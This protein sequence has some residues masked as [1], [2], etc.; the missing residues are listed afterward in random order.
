MPKSGRKKTVTPAKPNLLH[1]PGFRNKT[2]K[3]PYECCCYFCARQYPSNTATLQVP[4]QD[5]PSFAVCWPLVR[6]SLPSAVSIRGSLQCK[7]LDGMSFR[8]MRF[9]SGDIYSN[10]PVDRLRVVMAWRLSV[11][12]SALVK[13]MYTSHPLSV[14]SDADVCM[15]LLDQPLHRDLYPIWGFFAPPNTKISS[16]H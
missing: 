4:T 13:M 7:R 15:L 6:M 12:N 8:Q 9:C 10:I 11:I 1:A 14:S 5:T 3:G 16:T 2:L